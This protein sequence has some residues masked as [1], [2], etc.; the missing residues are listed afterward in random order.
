MPNGRPGDSRTY[1]ILHHGLEVF[2]PSIDGLVREID[3]RIAPAERNGLVSLLESW[4]FEADGTPRD[5]DALFHRLATLRDGLGPPRPRPVLDPAGEADAPPPPLPPR[6]VGTPL[7]AAIGLLVG[8]F[9]GLPAGFLAYMVLREAVL[10]TDLWSSNPTMWAIIAAVALPSAAL[11]AM[12]G[13]R[14]TRMGHTLLI[15]LLGFFVG[16]L[17]SGLAAG[18]LAFGIAAI[19]GVSQREGSFAMGVVFSLMPMA[20]VVGGVVL[21]WWTGRRAWRDWLG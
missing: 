9:V 21:A 1:D 17:V 20:A 14:P 8:G 10:P 4:P 15:A 18:L 2:G 5:A 19:A 13:G 11:G 3:A 7:A 12:Q 6:R 16:S